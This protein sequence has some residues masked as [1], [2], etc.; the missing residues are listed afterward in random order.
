MVIRAITI[1]AGTNTPETLSAIL[2]TGAFVAAA[3]LTIFMICDKAVSSPTAVAL[4]LINPDL[5]IVPAD[6]LSPTVLSMGILSPVRADS[7]T[8]VLPSVISASTGILSPGRTTNTSPFFT[9]STVTSVSL[10]SINKVAFLGARFKSALSAF[11][12]LPFE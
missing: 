11:V 12:V 2:A 1:T 8:A 3:S 9:L 4:H 7:S 10:P 6:T 5:L